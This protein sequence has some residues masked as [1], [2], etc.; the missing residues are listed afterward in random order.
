MP[1]VLQPTNTV[2]TAYRPLV[3]RVYFVAFTPNS[4]KNCIFS[5]FVDGVLIIQG[6]KA[7]TFTQISSLGPTGTDYFFDVDIQQYLQRYF[8][9]KGK[10]STFGTLNAATQTENVDSF[11]DVVVWFQYEMLNGATGKLETL[12]AV[13]VSGTFHAGIT[14]RQNGEN[15][16]MDDYYGVPFVT[17]QKS[18]LTRSPLTLPVSPTENAFLSFVGE[19]NMTKVTTYDATGTIINIGYFGNGTG[20]FPRM[21]TIGVGK[22]QLQAITGWWN[23][24]A[25]NFTNAAYYTIESGVGISLTPS[26][27]F[28]L[29]NSDIRTYD[30]VEDCNRKLRFYW[31]NSLGGTD[32]YNFA[33]SELGIAVASEIFEKP[34]QS[35]HLQHDYGKARTNIKADRIFTC[36]KVF[37]N[38]E[39]AWIK[40][41]FYSAEVYIQNPTDSSQYWRVW[42]SDLT[43]TEKKQPGVFEA[44]FRVN[45]SQDIITHR[46]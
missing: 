4:I 3:W 24:V 12:P 40:D 23:T 39:M 1:I 17:A 26:S 25:P 22:P 27:M 46:I 37:I 20:T 8:A 9:K 35:P 30:F 10:R 15:Q 11:G 7:V 32:A 18:Y 36:T 34:L 2:N 19:W 14:T 28:F 6:R 41:L 42:L 43:I 44:Q 45:L 21:S 38:S 31:T 5:I 29:T 33:F 16:T 13:D